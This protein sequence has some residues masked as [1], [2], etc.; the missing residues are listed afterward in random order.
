[1]QKCH[2]HLRYT[3]VGRILQTNVMKSVG[4]ELPQLAPMQLSCPGTVRASPIRRT[5]RHQLASSDEPINDVRHVL[6][7]SI[8]R[9]SRNTDKETNSPGSV[10]DPCMDHQYRVHGSL[11]SRGQC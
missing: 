8:A 3:I 7:S 9:S 1:M 2:T 4:T 5:V 11:C 10:M 6:F